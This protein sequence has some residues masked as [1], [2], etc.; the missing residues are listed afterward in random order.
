MKDT[1]QIKILKTGE[2]CRVQRSENSLVE[3]RAGNAKIKKVL[4]I[5]RA[6]G[7]RFRWISWV[8][9]EVEIVRC[10]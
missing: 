10:R 5:E 7:K 2:S 3:F 9:G 8:P 1:N 4:W 6:K